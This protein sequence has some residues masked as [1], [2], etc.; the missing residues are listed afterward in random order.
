M[1]RF[2]CAVLQLSFRIHSRYRH[3]GAASLKNKDDNRSVMNL[4]SNRKPGAHNVSSR[5]STDLDDNIPPFGEKSIGILEIVDPPARARR[6]RPRA[7][8]PSRRPPRRKR[9]RAAHRQRRTLL[10]PGYGVASLSDLSDLSDP[11][12]L[13]CPYRG[14]I[15]RFATE[16]GE[17]VYRHTRP[18]RRPSKAQKTTRDGQ[19]KASVVCETTEA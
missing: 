16:G 19:K 9:P 4:H 6:K 5:R 8:Y 2:F 11:T 7:A 17:G 3:L 18:S 15:L 12:T 10:R 14:W 13:F 1:S